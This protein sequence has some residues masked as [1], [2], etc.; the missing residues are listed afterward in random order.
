M[1]ATVTQGEKTLIFLHLP[2]TGGMTLERLIRRQYPRDATRWI[3]YQ[4][5]RMVDEFLALSPA[6]L[7]VS[8]QS[9]RANRSTSPCCA[10][11]WR[12]SC[13]ST[14]SS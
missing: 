11:R 12:V 6:C 8:T 5:P 1:D 13:P 3:S 9:F 14:A 10:S 7:T 2:K 4:R